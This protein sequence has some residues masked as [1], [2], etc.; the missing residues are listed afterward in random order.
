VPVLLGWELAV[1]AWLVA[2]FGL[3]AREAHHRE[4]WEKFPEIYTVWCLILVMTPCVL[5]W[6]AWVDWREGRR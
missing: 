2:A 4:A 1:S 6:F 3:A 5:L